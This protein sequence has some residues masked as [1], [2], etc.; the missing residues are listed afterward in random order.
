MIAPFSRCLVTAKHLSQHLIFDLFSLLF[1]MYI[2]VWPLSN[3]IKKE[4]GMSI[5]YFQFVSISFGPMYDS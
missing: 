4:I 5:I 3:G 2:P 1:I